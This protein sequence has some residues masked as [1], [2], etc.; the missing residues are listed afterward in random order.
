MVITSEEHEFF[1]DG[2]RYIRH[3]D[4]VEHSITWLLE[5]TPVTSPERV[6]ALEEEFLSQDNVVNITF[7]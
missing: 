2:K 1:S 5:G 3:V 7:L 6:A 4:L